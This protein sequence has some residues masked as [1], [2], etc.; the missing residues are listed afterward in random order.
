[1]LSAYIESLAERYSTEMIEL[2]GNMLETNPNRRISLLEVQRALNRW[3]EMEEDGL[4]E[5]EDFVM[6][7]SEKQELENKCEKLFAYEGNALPRIK[8]SN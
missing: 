8:E 6:D 5:E 1:M 4:N 2:L 3:D 7:E